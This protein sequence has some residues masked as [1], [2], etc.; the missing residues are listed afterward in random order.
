[1]VGWSFFFFNTIS[2]AVFNGAKKFNQDVSK[3]TTGA[4]KTMSQS[5]CTLSPSLSPRLPLLCTCTRILNVHVR[6]NSSFISDNVYNSHM[7]CYF[8]FVCLKT[9]RIF[10]VVYG[11]LVFLFFVEPSLAV[12]IFAAAFNSD[13]SKWNTG[14]VTNM[15]QRECTLSLPLHF[16]Y[17]TTRVLSDHNSHTFLLF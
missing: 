12:F 1:V 5:K 13:V 8:V 10:F 15:Q 3:W 2:L 14:A 17:T 6:Q 11:G 7:F 4:V 16:E 9:L